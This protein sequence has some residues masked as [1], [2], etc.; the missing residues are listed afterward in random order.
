MTTLLRSKIRSGVKNMVK[1]NKGHV[2]ELNTG[3]RNII[4]YKTDDKKRL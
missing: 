2:L 3:A 1:R 4:C